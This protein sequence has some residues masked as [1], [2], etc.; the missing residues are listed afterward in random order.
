MMTGPKSPPTVNGLPPPE[1]LITL[2]RD[3]HWVHPGEARLREVIPFLVDPVDFL[4]TPEAMA[5]E[6]SGRLADNPQF[7]AVYHMARGSR[8]DEP[9][10]LPW[11]DVDRSL[12]VAVN[13]VPGDDVAIGLDYRTDLLDP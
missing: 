2:I 5:S 13:H 6:S 11:L 7:S 10:D 12:V 9:V 8:M 1:L 4:G 3:G